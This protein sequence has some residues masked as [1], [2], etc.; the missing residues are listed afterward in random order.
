MNHNNEGHIVCVS[1]CPILSEQSG[2]CPA[3][4]HVGHRLMASI[5]CFPGIPAITNIIASCRCCCCCYW[6]GGE[7]GQVAQLYLINFLN[8]L[9]K[10]FLF[11]L[12]SQYLAGSHHKHLLSRSLPC[13]PCQ[14]GSDD[15]NRGRGDHQK[16]CGSWRRVIAGSGN[17]LQVP[18]CN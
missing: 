14:C 15:C 11:S 2:H 7:E 3:R 18:P 17:C 4:V 9:V 5:I 16:C 1:K 12:G 10:I 6:P 8:D 13:C